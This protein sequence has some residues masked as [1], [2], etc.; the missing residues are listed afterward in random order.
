MRS[1]PH[2]IRSVRIGIGQFRIVL[3]DQSIATL[4]RRTL[5]LR[6]LAARIGQSELACGHPRRTRQHYNRIDHTPRPVNLSHQSSLTPEEIITVI[7][8]H[9]L[10]EAPCSLGLHRLF[11]SFRHRRPAEN[12]V[13]HLYYYS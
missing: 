5:G 11:A 7:R 10:R 4:R 13:P 2:F 3:N 12:T 9:L 6:L 1:K 8:A